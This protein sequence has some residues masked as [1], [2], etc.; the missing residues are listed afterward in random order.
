MIAHEE[1][2][3]KIKRLYGHMEAEITEM[4]DMIQHALH[5]VRSKESELNMRLAKLSKRFHVNYINPF[6]QHAEESRRSWMWPF[7]FVFVFL[8]G[9]AATGYSKYKRYMKTHLL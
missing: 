7:I 6:Y 5:R 4:T 3:K 1:Q 8:L 9:F 2:N